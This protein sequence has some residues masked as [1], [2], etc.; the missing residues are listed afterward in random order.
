MRLKKAVFHINEQSLRLSG[1]TYSAQICDAAN[2]VYAAA[3]PLRSF[4]TCR[5]GRRCSESLWPRKGSE[6]DICMHA[7]S[8]MR[9]RAARCGH[10][11]IYIYIYAFAL[12]GERKALIRAYT[13][14]SSGSVNKYNAPSWA[15]IVHTH[16]AEMRQ[17]PIV[18]RRFRS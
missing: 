7:T 10:T 6:G 2:D 17:K 5:V 15:A 13:Y 4:A 9:G 18:N 11:H 12:R 14:T 3:L 8:W 16:K 1:R